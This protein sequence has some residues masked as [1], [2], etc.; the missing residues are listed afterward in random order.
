MLL[1]LVA[2]PAH[3][4]L[5]TAGRPPI[6]KLTSPVYDETNSLN[7]NQIAQLEEKLHRYEDS[8]STQIAVVIINDLGDYP[9]SDFAVEVAEE[10]KI[11]Q[12]KKNNGGLILISLNPRKA[13]IATGYGLEPTLTDLESSQIYR[14]I[15][16]PGLQQGDFYG[17]IDRA[18]TAM[19][20]AVGDEFKAD[21]RV[22]TAPENEP[23][24]IGIIITVVI[25]FVVLNIVRAL[26]GRGHRRTVIG[27]KGKGSG[28]LGGILEGLF[29]SALLSSGRNRGGWSGGGFGG[30]GGGG[31]GGGGGGWSGG[32]GSF[33][34]GGAG[35][36]W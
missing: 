1:L 36:S 24:P 16:R 12:E 30:F 22:Q 26:F 14:E 3:A 11:G 9:V 33:G 18:T 34:G 15:L 29:W 32:G 7:A 35:G 5:S 31:F 4:Q 13:W 6:P 25:F 23:S 8:T 28:C 21:P 20:Q 19:M 10:N 27:S 17:A 2:D